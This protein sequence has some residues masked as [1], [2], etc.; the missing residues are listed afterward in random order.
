MSAR[1]AVHGKKTTLTA[2]SQTIEKC[3][4]LRDGTGRNR[5]PDGSTE[6]ERRAWS[7]KKTSLHFTWTCVTTTQPAVAL[8]TSY[9]RKL[10]SG[11]VQCKVELRSRGLQPSLGNRIQNLSFATTHAECDGSCQPCA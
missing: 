9:S 10:L 5:C 1:E 6:D 7:A 8:N 3:G 4:H 2:M 11:L